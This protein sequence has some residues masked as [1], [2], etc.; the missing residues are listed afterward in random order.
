LVEAW[1]LK[2]FF[3]NT[4]IVQVLKNYHNQIGLPIIVVN[5]GKKNNTLFCI[6]EKSYIAEWHRDGSEKPTVA[7][8]LWVR[9]FVANSPLLQF[10]R[11][12]NV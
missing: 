2:V 11:K 8:G 12:T 7:T 1:H 6:D 3:R 4:K 9:G 10:I 5:C